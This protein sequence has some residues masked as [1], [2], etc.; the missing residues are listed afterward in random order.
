MSNNKT[1]FFP[2]DVSFVLGYTHP[3]LLIFSPL[4]NL[5]DFSG[6][7]RTNTLGTQSVCL[8]K[9]EKLV[10]LL[11]CILNVKCDFACPCLFACVCCV[12]VLLTGWAL[13]DWM[14]ANS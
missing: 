2:I 3:C 14:Q 7:N 4:L 9:K 10:V 5:H 8:K 13:E 11:F 6:L 12:F 1:T